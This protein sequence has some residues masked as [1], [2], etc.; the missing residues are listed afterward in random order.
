[1]SPGASCKF[2]SLIFR[3]LRIFSCSRPGRPP[4]PSPLVHPPQEPLV[5]LNACVQSPL[6]PSSGFP[7]FF[8]SF[9]NPFYFILDPSCLPLLPNIK[10]LPLR[11]WSFYPHWITASLWLLFLLSSPPLPSRA[12]IIPV[13]SSLRHPPLLSEARG[14]LAVAACLSSSPSSLLHINILQPPALPRKQSDPSSLPSPLS[15]P[16]CSAA[17]SL[18]RHAPVGKHDPCFYHPLVILSLLRPGNPA[19]PPRRPCALLS[20]SRLP[21]SVPHPSLCPSPLCSSH[22]PTR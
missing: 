22:L 8:F 20:R 18:T 3:V 6:I 10:E 14:P 5:I 12:L 16:R 1:M 2:V 9:Q 13:R 7:S 4:L 11:E 19:H 15:R 21:Q 17:V